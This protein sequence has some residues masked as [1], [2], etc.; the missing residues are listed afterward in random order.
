MDKKE[1]I[2]HLFSHSSDFI[3]Y[4]SHNIIAKVLHVYHWLCFSGQGV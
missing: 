2:K 3:S 1:I 4:V